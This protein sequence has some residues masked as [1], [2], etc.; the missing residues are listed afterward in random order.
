MRCHIVRAD[1]RSGALGQEPTSYRSKGVSLTMCQG[2]H[3]YYRA[4]SM[5]QKCFVPYIEV[6]DEFVGSH[7]KHHS[8]NEK[9][10]LY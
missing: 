6:S 1:C 9:V 8:K 4:D 5:S 7:S 10:S 3:G 2:S